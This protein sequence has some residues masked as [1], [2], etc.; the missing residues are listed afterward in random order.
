MADLWQDFIE[1]FQ[2][3][4]KEYI[5]YLSKDIAY[6]KELRE[7]YRDDW[8]IEQ[9]ISKLIHDESNLMDD[10]KRRWMYA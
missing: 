2:D 10:C 9:L 8:E 4:E 6:L 5:R 1:E 3:T 7:E